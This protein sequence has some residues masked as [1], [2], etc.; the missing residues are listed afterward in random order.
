MTWCKRVAERITVK[1]D[2]KTGYRSYGRPRS[3]GFNRDIST[4]PGRRGRLGAA[5][6]SSGTAC[7]A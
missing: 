1:V 3:S 6:Q 5:S 2:L 7:L 4:H